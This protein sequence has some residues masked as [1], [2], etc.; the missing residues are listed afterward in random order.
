M[1]KA[2][3]RVY[4]I[5]RDSR[6]VYNGKVIRYTKVAGELRYIISYYGVGANDMVFNEERIENPI[7][8]RVSTQIDTRSDRSFRRPKTMIDYGNRR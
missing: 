2:G 4:V 7:H 8:V 1:L 5:G 3:T 6:P